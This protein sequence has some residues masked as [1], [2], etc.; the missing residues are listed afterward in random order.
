M[1]KII[2]L[3]TKVVFCYALCGGIYVLLETAFKMSTTDISMFYLAGFVSLPALLCN[4]AFTYETD[5]L[6]QCGICTV[7]AIIG[8]GITGTIVNSDFG[9]WDYTNL[10]L[11]FWNGQ[12]NVF[13]CLIWFLLFAIFIPILDYIE[14]QLFGYKKDVIPYYKIFNR[15]IFDLGQIVSFLDNG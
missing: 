15:K 4:N 1:R 7:I 12:C 10:P 3:F 2:G 11:T 6:L 9:I 14:W 13:F 5:F 8:E